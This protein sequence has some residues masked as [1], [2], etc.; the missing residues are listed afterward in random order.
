MATKMACVGDHAIVFRAMLITGNARSVHVLPSGDVMMRFDVVEPDERA[1]AISPRAGDHAMP[2]LAVVW[3]SARPLQLRPSRV[4][5]I[6][7]LL[8][9]LFRLATA[10]VCFISGI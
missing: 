10:N 8:P 9:P 3:S 1:M 2:L 5:A 7:F 4:E 6:T